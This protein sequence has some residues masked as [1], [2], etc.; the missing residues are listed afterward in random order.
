MKEGMEVELMVE[1]GVGPEK[2]ANDDTYT[3]LELE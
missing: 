1:D 3:E 2:E